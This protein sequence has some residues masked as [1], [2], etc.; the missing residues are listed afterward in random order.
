ML[1]FRWLRIAL[2]TGIVAFLSIFFFR[3]YTELSTNVLVATVISVLITA[4][5]H[6]GRRDGG[7]EERQ[8]NR[9]GTEPPF[10]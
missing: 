3:D 4:V 9:I 7:L 5:Y 2:P 10:R 6:W 1:N 8:K